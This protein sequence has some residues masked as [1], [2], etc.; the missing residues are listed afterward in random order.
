MSLS[1]NETL[2]LKHIFIK[3]KFHKIWLLFVTNIALQCIIVF[4]TEE[5]KDL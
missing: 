1:N 4:E 5:R 3:I 2:R